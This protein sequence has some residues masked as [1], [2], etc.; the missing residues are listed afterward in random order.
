MRTLG[1]VLIV[2]SIVAALFIM[3]DS[4][5]TI[6]DRIGGAGPHDPLTYSISTKGEPLSI[7]V[8]PQS[9]VN[10]T[11]YFDGKQIASEGILATDMGVHEL[12]IESSNI[13]TFKLTVKGAGVSGVASAIDAGYA[14]VGIALFWRGHSE[15]A[16]EGRPNTSTETRRHTHRE[17]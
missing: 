12:R 17:R 9:S 4:Q 15:S 14:A 8:R 1:L 2:T 10:F 5:S 6:I 3:M 13:S 16:S 7:T 11:I